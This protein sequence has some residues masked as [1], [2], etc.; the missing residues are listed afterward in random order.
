MNKL[1]G[2]C[3]AIVIASC[4]LSLN[5]CTSVI[6]ATTDKPIQPDPSKRTFGTYIDDEQLETIAEVNLTKASPSLDSSHINV[7]AF[8]GVVLVTGEVPNQEARELATS[9]LRKLHKVRQVFN[10]LQIQGNSSFL[11][12][13]NDS[14]ISS[15]VKTQLL[16]NEDID[17][18]RIKVVTE[19]GTVYLMGTV[20]R[21]QA[22]KAAN[23]VS[24]IGGVQKVVRTFE[25]ID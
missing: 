20:T 10:E 24:R 14:W 1:A 3:K 6:S 9:T 11:G 4:V 8:N 19:N 12:R 5:A 22:N 13:T 7:N 25:Y 16:A 17:S 23:V 18:G 21:A 15:K 2:L